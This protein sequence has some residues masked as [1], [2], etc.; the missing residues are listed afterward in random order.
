MTTEK[1]WPIITKVYP[2]YEENIE[3]KILGLSLGLS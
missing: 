2:D 1:Y 3:L